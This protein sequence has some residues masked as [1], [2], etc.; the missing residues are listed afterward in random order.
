MLTTP[1]HSYQRGILDQ[2]LA[3]GNLLLAAEQGTGKTMMSIAAAEHLL[4]EGEISSALVICPTGLVYQWA[5]AIAAHTDVPTYQRRVSG[6][7]LTVPEPSS[8]LIIIGGAARR[9]LLLRQALITC[10]EYVIIAYDTALSDYADVLALA[11]GL[12]VIDE[13]S[14]IK[15]PAA[16]RTKCLKTLTGTH[17][18]ALT[19][20]PVENRPE[21]VF[22][23]ME[24]VDDRVLGRADMF[25]RA[26]IVRNHWGRPVRY[27]NLPTLHAKLSTAM[28]RITV[29]HPEVAPHMPERDTHAWTV[30]MTEAGKRTYI[31]LARHLLAEME[32][33]QSTYGD[34]DVAA[35]YAGRPDESTPDGRLMAIHQAML[36]YCDHPRLVM[37]SG[38]AH[39]ADPDR[40]SA[41]CAKL[42][43]GG[44]IQL[45]HLSNWE[46]F[47]A[48]RA[49]IADILDFPET[50][51]IVFTG[52]RKMVDLF[53]RVLSEV[54]HVLYH[55]GMST[56]Q[57]A[58]AQAA[59]EGDPSIRVMVA[60]H[61]G[62]YGLDLPSA[63]HLINYDT[64]WAHGK[65]AQINARHVR[66][67]S[68]HDRVHIF[69][70]VTGD[71][72]EERKFAVMQGKGR[73][74]S[75]I[76]DGVGHEGR[77]RGVDA[78]PE[79]LVAHLRRTVRN[80]A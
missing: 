62:A 25:D 17:R 73:A 52:Y 43:E 2:F 3:R 80:A 77:D 12:V 55:G 78:R 31:S 29:D 22:S 23:I 13:A 61:A 63:T 32:A 66:V 5:Q 51:V 45:E 37:E 76:V 38:L 26:F 30:G 64:A 9:A 54:P 33:S 14:V 27:K 15:N 75:A 68:K 72:V 71:T 36:M 10:P 57:K 42:L 28:A 21:E 67:N 65:Q 6:K 58:A 19:G 24:W 49:A 7:L 39:I 34:F 50:K 16:E 47:N 41:F 53:D 79:S 74:A 48:A 11:D 60:S 35:H 20:T 44:E 18:L 69:Y 59:F 1:L 70:I 46:K 8:C 40:G 56:G 4:G